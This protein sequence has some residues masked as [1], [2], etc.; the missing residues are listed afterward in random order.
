MKML[1][2]LSN[3]KLFSDRLDT[4]E[5]EVKIAKDMR[6][7]YIVKAFEAGN[8]QRDIGH[9]CNLSASTVKHII[10]KRKK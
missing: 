5:K 2:Q 8:R 1:N 3:V 9:V 6:D 4:F 10:A 7:Y